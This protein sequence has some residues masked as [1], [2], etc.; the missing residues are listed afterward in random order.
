MK[1]YIKQ[2]IER[3]EDNNFAR[4][5][6]REYLQAR[7]LESLQESGAFENWAFVGGTALRFLYSM[8]RFSEDMDFSL[9]AAG[10]ED[11]FTALM[12]RTKSIFAAE[13]YSLIIRAKAEKTVKNAFLNFEGLLYE[14]ELSPHSS[15]TI[16]I[17]VEIDTNPPA[18][19]DFETS[20]IRK[21]CL[22][23]LQHYDR[24]SLLAGKLHA[25]LSRK[26][27]KGRDIYDL[28]WYLSD[29]NWP[30]PN[31]TL[32]N[33]ALKQ[34]GWQGRTVTSDNWRSETA[35]RISDYDWDKVITDVRP[36]V[37][38]QQDLKL[39]TKEN[40]LKMLENDVDR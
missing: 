6:V 9:S 3:I 27:V 12:K 36:F 13:G 16:S 17:K 28:F 37:E 24:A 31:I 29:R 35:L 4:C 10:R 23:N 21:H 5:I 38:R 20:I 18:G 40:L 33:N 32:L 25:M 19:A 34:T 8:P 11:N 15:E 14:L 30:A 26:Y 2:I 39:L 22:L 1:D 7:L